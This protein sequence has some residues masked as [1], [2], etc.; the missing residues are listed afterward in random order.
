MKQIVI[1]VSNLTE[2]FLG[3]EVIQNCAFSVERGSIY[4]FL[5]CNGAGKTTVLNLLLGVVSLWFGSRKESAS[6]TIVASVILAALVFLPIM[7][8]VFGVIGIVAILAIQ[9]LLR[10][11]NN[12]EL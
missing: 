5:G 7:G 8:I 12:K 9:N 3:K 2:T 4:V 6:V 10:Q 11:V 1:S